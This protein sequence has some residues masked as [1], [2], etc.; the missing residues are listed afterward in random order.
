[1]R[2]ELRPWAESLLSR[3]ALS[4]SGL[5]EVAPIRRC[6]QEHLEGKR[7]RTRAIWNVLMFQAWD[8][9]RRADH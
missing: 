4:S 3:D 2:Q 6:W 5:L 8:Q 7:F 9:A 1:L